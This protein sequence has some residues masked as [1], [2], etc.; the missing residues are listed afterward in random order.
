[1]APALLRRSTAAEAALV[2][3]GNAGT[4]H[5]VHPEVS[6]LRRPLLSTLVEPAVS[7]P[8]API[9]RRF[10]S[11]TSEDLPTRGGYEG[12]MLPLPFVFHS[13]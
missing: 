9:A 13:Q 8:R 1:M 5:T 2:S 3:V 4:G 12:F 6:A 10:C 7:D 11:R